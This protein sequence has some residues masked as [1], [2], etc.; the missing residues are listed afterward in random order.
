MEISIKSAS[1]MAKVSRNTIYQAIKDGKIS[2]SH[3]GKVESSEVLRVYG[4]PMDRHTRQE[5]IEHI[6]QLKSTLNIERQTEQLLNTL[7]SDKEELY[8]AQIK[9]LEDSLNKAHERE[10]QHLAREE[11]QRKHIE[12]LT[13]TLKLLEKPKAEEIEK[14]KGFLKRLFNSK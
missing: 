12:K 6:E 5:E 11:W 2:R 8:K 9:T 1:E 4:N 13:D 7:S 10:S 3:N 14:P